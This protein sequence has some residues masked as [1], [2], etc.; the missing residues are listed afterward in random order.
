M[1]SIHGTMA[2]KRHGVKCKIL[3]CD[4]DGFIKFGGW[5]SRKGQGNDGQGNLGEGCLCLIPLT[6][7]S[8]TLA[9]SD[10]NSG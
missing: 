5:K 8:L 4:P 1:L 3:K 2:E 9:F 10:K 6:I 7:I